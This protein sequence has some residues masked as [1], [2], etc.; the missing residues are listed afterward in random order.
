MKRFLAL[1][2][3]VVFLS[4]AVMGCGDT[5]TIDGVTYDTYGLFNADEKKNP[6]I[7]YRLIVGN[8]VWGVILFETIAAPIYFFGF[9]IFEPVGKKPAIKGQVAN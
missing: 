1:A 9:S 6:D 8:V 4:V 5:K 7:E 2:I 3:V